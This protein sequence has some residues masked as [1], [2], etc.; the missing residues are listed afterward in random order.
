[1]KRTFQVELRGAVDLLSQHLYSSSRIYVRELLQNAVDAITARR[2]SDP[3]APALVHVEPPERTGDGTLRVHDSG[4]GMSREQ[5]HALLGTIGR[6][7]R[8]DELGFPSDAFLGRLGIGLLSCFLVADEIRVLT[9]AADPTDSTHEPAVLW[10][11]HIDGRCSVEDA[12]RAEPGTT[13]TLVPRRGTEHW[14]AGATV[15]EL[16]AHYGAFLPAAITVA[17]F[18][19]AASDRPLPWAAAAGRTAAARRPGLIAYAREQLDIVP[20]DVIEL[21]VPEAGLTGVAFVLSTPADPAAPPAH[22][23]HVKGMPLGER[24]PGLLPPWA[25]FVRC[26]VD[27]TQLRITADRESLYEDD[28]LAATRTA[29]GEQV[30]A[31]LMRLADT[32]PGALAEFLQIHELGVQAVALHDEEM[33]RLVDRAWPLETTDG[34]MTPAEFR[35]RHGVLRYLA[36]ADEFRQL[37]GVAAAQDVPVINGGAPRVGELLERL[38][39]IDHEIRVEQLL[40]AE[41]V[42]HFATVP[43]SAALGLHPFLT[44]AQQALDRLG[45]EVVIRS[46]DPPSLPALYLV[47][48]STVLASALPGHDRGPTDHWA[49]DVAAGDVAAGDVAADDIWADVVGA[50]AAAQPPQRPQLV[51]NH[52][53]PVV[54]RVGALTDPATVTLAVEA[55]YGQALLQG[56]HPLRPV[57]AALLNGSFLELLGRAV[58][59]ER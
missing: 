43:P 48:R 21:A 50:L 33:L 41:L 38:A 51:L 54:R 22:R 11:G 56:H 2:V 36:D 8:V 23:V 52:R 20:L 30:R 44:A 39:G 3:G 24:V 55:L 58:A 14:L 46:F 17:G 57:D 13:V 32:D 6:S 7:S 42:T 25:F 18:P 40:P 26:A 35:E 34:P 29:L 12:E 19:T 10:T 4:S 47:S 37:G 59:G 28:L 45:C 49:G 27:T 9:R 53:N 5:V 31:W 16:V 1:M 15:A